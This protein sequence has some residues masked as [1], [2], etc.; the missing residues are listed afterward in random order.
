MPFPEPPGRTPWRHSRLESR[1]WDDGV[2]VRR[3]PARRRA[4]GGLVLA[5]LVGLAGTV[6]WI[7]LG[8]H[9]DGRAL[10]RLYGDWNAL[11]VH[12]S[13][14]GAGWAPLGFIA[15]QTAQVLVAPRKLSS[16][17]RQSPSEIC[18]QPS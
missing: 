10:L 18:E 6:A 15:M 2:T 4:W 8:E 16:G 3:A 12:L 5:I 17:M 14:W 11:R 1:P 7:R 9:A 13:A